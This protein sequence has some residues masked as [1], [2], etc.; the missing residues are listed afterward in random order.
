M[1]IPEFPNALV[2]ALREGGA[3]R[4]AHAGDYRDRRPL[5]S[6]AGGSP[7][8]AFSSKQ[9]SRN[10]SRP[11]PVSRIS[12]QP[13]IASCMASHLPPPE[14][15]RRRR[16]SYRIEHSRELRVDLPRASI[17]EVQR[18]NLAVGR[19]KVDDG[20]RHLATCVAAGGGVSTSLLLPRHKTER[21]WGRLGG[22]RGALIPAGFRHR[23]IGA[24]GLG[25][26]PA[27]QRQVHQRAPR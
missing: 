5:Q 22:H 1:N 7:G 2:V 12:Y 3:P 26:Q 19:L 15:Q 23:R 8:V 20:P 6:A 11:G 25:E 27:A 10:C 24:D 18:G 14:N 9:K 16:C 13:A 21:S 4:F 17:K